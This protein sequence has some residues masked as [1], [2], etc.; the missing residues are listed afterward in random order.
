VINA[1]THNYRDKMIL[2]FVASFGLHYSA[3]IAVAL[4]N[5]VNVNTGTNS[6]NVNGFTG[7]FQKLQILLLD[8]RPQNP[9]LYCPSVEVFSSPR[10]HARSASISKTVA[11][12]IKKY[13][14]LCVL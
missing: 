12:R 3:N 8:F 11:L 9:L 2:L 7:C 14:R 6:P 1:Q 13:Y 4:M 5:F 10:R